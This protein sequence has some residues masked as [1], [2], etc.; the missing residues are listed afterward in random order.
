[1]WFMN[2][3]GANPSIRWS[4]YSEGVLQG[5]IRGP[6]LRGVEILGGGVRIQIQCRPVFAKN[7][8]FLPKQA[9]TFFYPKKTRTFFY[10]KNTCQNITTKCQYIGTHQLKIFL[11]LKKVSRQT[12]TLCPQIWGKNSIKMYVKKYL[13]SLKFKVSK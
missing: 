13:S 4:C 12:N 6:F 11:S 9:R 3:C 2:I 8:N 5:Q 1:M 7:C 10:P